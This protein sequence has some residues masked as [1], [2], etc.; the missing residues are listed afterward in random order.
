MSEVDKETE[1]VK[2]LISGEGINFNG[3]KKKI[4][5]MGAVIHSIDKAVLGEEEIIKEPI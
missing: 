3:V 4:E 5:S 1:T 2:L